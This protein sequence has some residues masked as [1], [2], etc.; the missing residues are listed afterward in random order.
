MLTRQ[1]HTAE[2]LSSS[3]PSLCLPFCRV[4]FGDLGKQRNVLGMSLSSLLDPSKGEHVFAESGLVH[5][6]ENIL[7][8]V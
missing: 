2:L 5:F 6:T 1:V 3:V 4:K 7:L 8:R